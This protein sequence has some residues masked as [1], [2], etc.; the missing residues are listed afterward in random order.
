[1]SPPASPR[2]PPAGGEHPLK[3]VKSL[4]FTEIYLITGFIPPFRGAG[5]LPC[6]AGCPSGGLPCPTGCPSGGL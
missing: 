6:R 1:M 3:G 4:P 2:S 5:G